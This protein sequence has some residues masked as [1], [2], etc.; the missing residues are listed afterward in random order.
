LAAILL[1]TASLS[2]HSTTI[3]ISRALTK[4]FHK[5]FPACQRY[6]KNGR[7]CLAYTWRNGDRYQIEKMI[8]MSLVYSLE[9]KIAWGWKSFRRGPKSMQ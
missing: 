9:V 5:K 3:S 2:A 4:Q 1:T 8:D 6:A 7:K